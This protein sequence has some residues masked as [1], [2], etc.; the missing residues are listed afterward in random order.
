MF[1]FYLRRN[2][3][4]RGE[5]SLYLVY[6]ILSGRFGQIC[7]LNT[8]VCQNEIELFSLLLFSVQGRF[9]YIFEASETKNA[10]KKLI[11]LLIHL[12][13]VA[14][15]EPENADYFLV[16]CPVKSRIKTDI[17]EALEKIPGRSWSLNLAELNK[18]RPN[19]RS[20]HC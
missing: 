20:F 12:G 6:L 4:N 10:Y 16:F 8:C 2:S 5:E 1:L 3:D 15:E 17:D 19:G 7:F 18:N 13:H 11:S 14:V 9:F